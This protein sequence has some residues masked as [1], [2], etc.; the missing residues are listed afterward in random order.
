MSLTANAHIPG[1]DIQTGWRNERGP[2]CGG[3]QIRIAVSAPNRYIVMAVKDQIGEA[4]TKHMRSLEA[5]ADEKIKNKLRT[6]NINLV[7][8]VKSS[9]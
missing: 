1:M 9:Q 7:L 5:E 3:F 6:R 8:Y 2:F 4:V